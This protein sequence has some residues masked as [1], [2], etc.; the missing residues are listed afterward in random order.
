MKALDLAA[1]LLRN[2]TDSHALTARQYSYLMAVAAGL[3]DAESLGSFFGRGEDLGGAASRAL[4]L[5][6]S[7]G[8][9]HPTEHEWGTEFNLTE[10]GK[11][12]VV[13]MLPK[14]H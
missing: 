2:I 5:L 14:L 13:K 6:T 1:Y 8:Y 3:R 7:Q 12:E 4:N 10:K 9:L 11:A